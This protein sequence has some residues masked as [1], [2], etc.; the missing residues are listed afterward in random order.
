[1]S[2]M[3]SF[4]ELLKLLLSL[5][6]FWNKVTIDSYNLYFKEIDTDM[7][8]IDLFNNYRKYIIFTNTY[9]DNG[10]SFYLNCAKYYV[11]RIARIA[12][13]ILDCRV[14]I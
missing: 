9:I 7:K 6:V 1:M 3:K 4:V 2:Y 10:E 8:N 12:F 13:I 11:P 14:E 5:Y